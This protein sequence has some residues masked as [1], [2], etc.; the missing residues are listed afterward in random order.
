MVNSIIHG[1]FRVPATSALE[2]KKLPVGFSNNK[3]VVD[4][5]CDY[6][7]PLRNVIDYHERHLVERVGETGRKYSVVSSDARKHFML[8]YQSVESEWAMKMLRFAHDN[9][10]SVLTFHDGFT[11][12]R[13]QLPI[14]KAY[15]DVVLPKY[16]STSIDPFIESDGRDSDLIPTED[17]F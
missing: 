2:G 9:K 7:P 13:E 5:L 1:G 8:M 16:L 14:F 11:V 3:E 10:L 6:L 15:S 4:A 12:P 17:D